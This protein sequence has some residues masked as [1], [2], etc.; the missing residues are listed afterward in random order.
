VVADSA[1]LFEFTPVDAL[2]DGTVITA[3]ASNAAGEN[4]HL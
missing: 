4:H 3:T 2:A 1:G